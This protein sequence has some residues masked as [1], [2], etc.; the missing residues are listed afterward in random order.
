MNVNSNYIRN[1][2]FDQLREELS[3]VQNNP[4][5]ELLIRKLMKQKYI[6]LRK[7]KFNKIDRRFDDKYNKKKINDK[8]ADDL[9][10]EINKY[11]PKKSHKNI[12][13]KNINTKN[14]NTK[15]INT[16][17][18]LAN[19]DKKFIPEIEKDDL[20]NN[21]MKRMNSNIDIQSF[22]NNSKKIFDTPF[23][24]NNDSGNYANINKIPGTI[25]SNDFMPYEFMR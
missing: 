8:L 23:S 4:V 19:I 15:N 5:K 7:N 24:N 14:I 11:K 17:T 13:T 3:L 10:Y 22:R 9:L 16:N 25:Q 21:M 6:E 2:S 12:N 20:N 18:S 1:M